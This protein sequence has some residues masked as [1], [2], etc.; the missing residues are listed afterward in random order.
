MLSPRHNQ[1]LK[2]NRNSSSQGNTVLSM[3]P[4]GNSERTA[5][6]EGP[7]KPQHQSP[8]HE[9][10][11]QLG[12]AGPRLDTLGSGYEAAACSDVLLML[13]RMDI[14]SAMTTP[15]GTPSQA[16]CHA[17]RSHALP[18][19]ATEL[20][21][22]A[23][24]DT[25]AETRA[26]ETK[27]T[28]SAAPGVANNGTAVLPAAGSQAPSVSDGRITSTS[29]ST[30]MSMGMMLSVVYDP[31]LKCAFQASSDMHIPGQYYVLQ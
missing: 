2:L 19:L 8:P 5:T 3:V 1:L 27:H 17:T 4:A 9:Q 15:A 18:R 29:T 16:S 7:R 12:A 25:A 31:V 21:A 23:A 26:S 14:I 13:Q 6:H 30:S 28:A 20:Q 22:A 10:G 11:K 24:L